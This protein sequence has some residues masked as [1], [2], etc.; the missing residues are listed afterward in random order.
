MG[1]TVHGEEVTLQT[2]EAAS[3]RP[4]AHQ[5]RP[6]HLEENRV[7]G[8]AE[9]EK[10]SA[11]HCSSVQ[12]VTAA[13]CSQTQA[14]DKAPTSAEVYCFLIPVFSVCMPK[15]SGSSSSSWYLLVMRHFFL[16]FLSCLKKQRVGE[17][18]R[19][20][21]VSPPHLFSESVVNPETA[22]TFVSSLTEPSQNFQIAP[23]TSPPHFPLGY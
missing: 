3:F 5:V 19:N 21:Q 11:C 9:D 16:L 17:L 12:H 14:V 18:K 4:R 10:G 22:V 15:T 8:L 20:F 1:S 2:P 23:R 7:P 13:A 6:L